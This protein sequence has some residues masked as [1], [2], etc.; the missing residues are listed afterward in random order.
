MVYLTGG[1]GG[2]RNTRSRYRKTYFSKEE[3]SR[4]SPSSPYL[5]FESRLSFSFFFLFLV[6]RRD[7]VITRLQAC[8]T[9]I[10]SFIRVSPLR[11]VYNRRYNFIF[12]EITVTVFIGKG[13][14]ARFDRTLSSGS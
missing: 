6:K 3:F 13:S 8:R 14:I 11:R 9:A 5:L 4:N 7:D 12:E 10:T 2:N 1:E